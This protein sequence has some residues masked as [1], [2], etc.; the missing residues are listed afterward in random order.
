LDAKYDG[1]D[2]STDKVLPTTTHRK[3][4]LGQERGR[5]S[6]HEGEWTYL[7]RKGTIWEDRKNRSGDC[8]SILATSSLHRFD[9]ALHACCMML[10]P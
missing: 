3:A 2:G 5:H 4:G 9:R 1:V 8:F 6:A 7:V 10:F